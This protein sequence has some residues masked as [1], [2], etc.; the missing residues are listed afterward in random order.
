M[1]C[2]QPTHRGGETGD[3]RVGGRWPLAFPR[4]SLLLLG[5]SDTCVA[6]AS[7]VRGVCEG[8]PPV[9]FFFAVGKLAYSPKF[10][11]VYCSC[12]LP[13]PPPSL[14]RPSFFIHIGQRHPPAPIGP[15][16]KDP[17]SR[18][19]FY[20]PLASHLGRRKGVLAGPPSL[21]AALCVLVVGVMFFEDTGFNACS[22]QAPT[23][24]PHKKSPRQRPTQLG[25][26]FLSASMTWFSKG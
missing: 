15:R 3:A 12:R 24:F 22:R 11:A 8:C 19:R 9:L 1:S 18:D 17:L 2:Q 4:A 23:A 25:Q 20:S 14:A 10:R 6:S 16:R 26:P 5:S 21:G 7:P 13:P